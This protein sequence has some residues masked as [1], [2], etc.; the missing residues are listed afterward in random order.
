MQTARNPFVAGTL[1]MLVP[2][3][4]Q[5]YAGAR[6]L[7]SLLLLLTG[8]TAV[9]AL[10]HVGEMSAA[11]LAAAFLRSDVLLALFVANAIVAALRLWIVADAWRRG[12]FRRPGSRAVRISAL[13]LLC[14][15]TAAPHAVGAY[16]LLTARSVVD[17]VF[18][19]A[20]PRDVLP[21][22]TPDSI[23]VRAAPPPRLRAARVSAKR[24]RPRVP[25]AVD[26][27]ALFVD[28]GDRSL[29]SRLG[30]EGR[31]T[32]ILLVG[33]DAGAYRSGLRT[34]TMIVVAL[35]HGTGKAA[36]F[37]IPRNML[38]VPL[39]GRA[40]TVLGTYPEILNSLYSYARAHPELWLGGRDAGATALKQTLS[41]LLGIRISYSA[42]VDLRGFAAMID[43]LGG[44]R[45]RVA[46][47]IRDRLS[48]V[49]PGE[50]WTELDL[51]PG[52]VVKLDG[53]QALAYARSRWQ[54]SDYRRMQRQR[55]L[56]SAVAEQVNVRRLL[57]AFPRLAAAARDNVSTDIPIA[58]VARLV[59]L[60]GAVEPGRT[61]TIT[62][63][64]PRYVAGHSLAG[65]VPELAAIRH[66][67]RDA[68][69]LPAS[70]FRTRTGEETIRLDC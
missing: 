21:P 24:T 62:L 47:R 10:R 22:L 3:V 56:L 70:R 5:I 32:T 35:Q 8:V 61:V 64:P 53:R 55:C 40:A 30:A 48:P 2:G 36:A 45:V 54:S 68:I 65:T 29:Q 52:D 33:G 51:Y 46:E 43:A 23:F 1:S 44:V 13:A 34:D 31:W 58:R 59:E 4:G 19:D 38:R 60:V 9:A 49:N 15:L 66:V 57:R 7:G 67:V 26:G 17:T 6:V 42:L 11:E 50:P 18:A 37:G 12:R 41:G 14:C 27:R 28:S 16:A 69:L 20:E 25:L 39:T 63:G